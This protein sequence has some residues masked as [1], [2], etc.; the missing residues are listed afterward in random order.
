LNS[1]GNF[2]DGRNCGKKKT[3]ISSKGEDE[4]W[5]Q[6]S[7]KV[8]VKIGFGEGLAKRPTSGEHEV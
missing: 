3:L 6:K 2:F 8:A 4:L 5:A 7:I 1:R